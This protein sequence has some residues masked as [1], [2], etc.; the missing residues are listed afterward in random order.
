ME[1]NAEADAADATEVEA[2]AIFDTTFIPPLL[3]NPLTTDSNSNSNSN[4][5]KSYVTI[6]GE[7]ILNYAFQDH[8]TIIVAERPVKIK[9]FGAQ[10]NIATLAAG[11]HF[12]PSQ[13]FKGYGFYSFRLQE[14]DGVTIYSNIFEL[15]YDHYQAIRKHPIVI[16]SIYIEKLV[17][18]YHGDTWPSRESY[19]STFPDMSEDSNFN[20]DFVSEMLRLTKLPLIIAG[21]HLMFAGYHLDK[22][23][24]K[25]K[26]ETNKGTG[27]W[28]DMGTGEKYYDNIGNLTDEQYNSMMLQA[29]SQGVQMI[30]KSALVI[31]QYKVA[32]LAGPC[33]LVLRVRSSG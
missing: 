28:G 21:V 2:L 11:T 6:V 14:F 27:Y 3:Q 5:K 8:D 32:R 22:L 1:V 18:M 33:G 25:Y 10:S 23:C 9:C 24:E 7:N 31:N 16:N 20:S 17:D 29:T 13:I 12:F 4:S 15:N 30:P 19:I 26:Q